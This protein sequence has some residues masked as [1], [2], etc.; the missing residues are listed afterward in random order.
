MGELKIIYIDHS[1]GASG[2]QKSLLSLME[3][4]DRTQYGCAVLCPSSSLLAE[5]AERLGMTVYPFDYIWLSRNPL[6]ALK[7]IPSI[8]R[9]VKLVRSVSKNEMQVILHTNTAVAAVYGGIASRMLSLPWV[10]HVR[11]ILKPGLHSYI[12]RKMLSAFADS[13]VCVSNATRRYYGGRVIAIYNGI[14]AEAFCRGA[15]SDVDVCGIGLPSASPIVGMVGQMAKWKGHEVLVDAAPS[16]IKRFP[17]V[18]FIIVGESIH[19]DESD[20]SLSKKI[21]AMGLKDK[22][23][24]TGYREDIASL[25]S[26]VDVYV[27]PSIYADPLPRAI[28]EAMASGKAIVASDI[29]GIKEMITNGV[30]GLLVQP[31]NARELAWAVISVLNN[32]DFAEGLGTKARKKVVEKFSLSGHVR[33]IEQIYKNIFSETSRRA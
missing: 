8:A 11:D 16:I 14:D 19:E 12:Y 21:E 32:A 2:A 23:I 1:L 33:S 18:R 20:R 15:V 27:H 22:F 26:V 6:T 3:N 4:L 28:L 24:F 30:D 29:G 13:I 7:A 10:C 5:R 31:G 25:L 17:K 9:F